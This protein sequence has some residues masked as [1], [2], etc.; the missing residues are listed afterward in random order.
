MARKFR[1]R[2]ET[3][4]KI[5][6]RGQDAQRRVVADRLRRIAIIENQMTDLDRQ[7]DETT[8]GKREA[9]NADNFSVDLLRKQ[10][11]IRIWLDRKLLESQT[12]LTAERAV[13]NE[14]QH[15]LAQAATSLRVIEKLR[16]RQ[17][18]RHCVDVMREERAESDEAALRVA[19]RNLEF[20]SVEIK[21]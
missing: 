17:W 16:E 5:R 11:V 7:V 6:Q 4:Q 20:A 1:F 15:K 3:V 10:H 13:L 9:Q 18:E 21:A 14:E 2:L 8:S 19:V 12:Q